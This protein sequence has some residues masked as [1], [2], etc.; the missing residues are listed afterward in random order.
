MVTATTETLV[1]QCG[2]VSRYYQP[3]MISVMCACSLRDRC[4]LGHTIAIER[5]NINITN[6]K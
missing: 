2:N 3:E 4:K 1:L 5:V 6:Q